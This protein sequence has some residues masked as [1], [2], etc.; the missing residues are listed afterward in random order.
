MRLG[1]LLFFSFFIQE[2]Y[3]LACLVNYF[4][5]SPNFKQLVIFVCW[6]MRVN[7]FLLHISFEFIRQETGV[8]CGDLFITYKAI[9]QDVRNAIDGIH[10]DVTL[11]CY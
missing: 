8:E 2:I 6:N 3:L 1:S 4:T 7:C 9:Y 10:N 11:I 5:T